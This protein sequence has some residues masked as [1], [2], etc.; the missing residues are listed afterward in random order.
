MDALAFNRPLPL[1]QNSSPFYEADSDPS[2]VQHSRS[3]GLSGSPAPF[4]L[5]PLAPPSAPFT[6]RSPSPHPTMTIDLPYPSASPS[7]TPAQ[8]YA[9]A[10]TP[11]TTSLE[12]VETERSLPA[13]PMGP[14]G[15]LGIH[16]SDDAPPRSSPLSTY[17]I[18]PDYQ[19]APSSSPSIGAGTGTGAPN[20]KSTSSVNLPSGKRTISAA[21]FKRPPPRK[22]GSDIPVMDTSPL[23][24]KKRLP[25]S[26]YPQHSEPSPMSR[27]SS[28]PPPPLPAPGNSHSNVEGGQGHQREAGELDEDYDY[29]SAYVNPGSPEDV[30]SLGP[31][32]IA[33]ESGEGSG[34]RAQG[35]HG[36]G[37]YA[38][39]RFTTDLEGLR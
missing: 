13:T 30:G 22:G 2:A 34:R 14:R 10:N 6:R 29:L 17:Q 16:P 25:S 38:D 18:P 9:M 11:S 1:P 32:R 33:N 27:S 24:L 20:P 36:R 26:P 31:L 23:M 7:I 21:A 5:S 12:R 15:T 4:E 39:G 37:G 3:P 35:G 28:L 8:A 19:R